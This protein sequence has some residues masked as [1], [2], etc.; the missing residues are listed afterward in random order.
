MNPEAWQNLAE[1]LARI[2]LGWKLREDY[3]ALLA[4][5]EGSLRIDLRSGESWCD[6]DPL[7]SLFIAA[8]LQSELEKVAPAPGG[9]NALGV[10]AL[11]AEF[12]TRTRWQPDGETPYLEIACRVCLEVSGREVVAHGSNQGPA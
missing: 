12:H 1:D 11:E 6:G 8:E 4:I 2:F 5:G 3:D 7:P 9:K 10:A